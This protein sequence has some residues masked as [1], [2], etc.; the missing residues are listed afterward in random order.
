MSPKP[1]TSKSIDMMGRVFG[2]LIALVV[3]VVAARAQTDFPNKP[4]TIIV[5]FAAGGPSDVVTRILAD[6]LTTIWNQ[7]IIVENKVGGGTVVGNAAAA[8]AK[9]DGYTLLMVAG[10][11]V[12][13]P[14]VRDSLP[15]DT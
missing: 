3:S 9:P 7:Q 12:V 6:E 5:P 11:F 10:A 1:P 8:R 13:L 14:G 4:V 2:F 15:Y